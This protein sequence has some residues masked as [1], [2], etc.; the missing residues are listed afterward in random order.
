MLALLLC[1]ATQ[2]SPVITTPAGSASVVVDGVVRVLGTEPA[3]QRKLQDLVDVS[4]PQRGAVVFADIASGRVLALAEH[5][6]IDP[7]HASAGLRPLA[8]AAS[9]FKL[10]TMSALLRKGV[11]VSDV[12]CSSGGG[13]RIYP[14]DLVDAPWRQDRCVRVEDAVPWSQNVTMAKLAGRHLTPTL[15]AEECER[16]GFVVPD[17]DSHSKEEPPPSTSLGLSSFAVIPDDDL[18]LF[19]TTAA[20]FGQVRL[21]GLDAARIARI[22]ATGS[23]A[24]LLL[25]A[26]EQPGFGFEPRAVLETRERQLL[27]SMMLAVT[28]RG[29]ATNALHGHV[30]VPKELRGQPWAVDVAIAGKT[31]SY[32]DRVAGQDI[33]WLMGFFPA[34]DPKVAFA[35]VVINDEW[36]WYTRALEIARASIASYLLLHPELRNQRVATKSS[37]SSS[38]A[39]AAQ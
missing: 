11:K 13:T 28:T 10:V 7:A 8:Y 19:A 39:L 3:L 20:G 30:K 18:Q 35:V 12:V 34:Q 25:F 36:L 1:L 2:P 27:Q 15:L 6:E 37:S 32:T 33:S 17:G 4:R 16:F 29:T 22:M 9:V 21:S 23:D 26:D 38:S 5:D 14:R 31:G 24:P